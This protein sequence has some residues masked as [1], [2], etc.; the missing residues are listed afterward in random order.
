MRYSKY[1]DGIT[2]TVQ[3]SGRGSRVSVVVDGGGT[4]IAD[5]TSTELATRL[6]ITVRGGRQPAN[7]RQDLMDAV[8]E[9]PE[10]LAPAVVAASIPL[11]DVDLLDEFNHRCNRVATRAAGSTCL[12]D[13]FIE[14][15]SPA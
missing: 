7:L 8:F 9:L 13:G 2:T 4:A 5:I 6:I 11:G 14:P 15:R 3:S 1:V 10:F 12:I